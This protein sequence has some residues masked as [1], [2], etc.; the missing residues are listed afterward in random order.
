MPETAAPVSSGH[1]DIDGRVPGWAITLD[2]LVGGGLIGWFGPSWYD[3]WRQ[4]YPATSGW[5]IYVAVIALWGFALAIAEAVI[6]QGLNLLRRWRNAA[7]S[8]QS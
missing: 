8:N 4:V 2:S 5:L 1:D 6:A 3:H 7:R